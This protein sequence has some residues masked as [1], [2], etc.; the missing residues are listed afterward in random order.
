MK[1]LAF[2]SSS[3]PETSV[4][5]DLS[6]T[7]KT[8]ME[9]DHSAYELKSRLAIEKQNLNLFEKY[10]QGVLESDDVMLDMDTTWSCSFVRDTS[11]GSGTEVHQSLSDSML[12]LQQDVL[13]N[14]RADKNFEM[15]LR[16]LLMN[17]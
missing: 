13:S 16:S 11:L 6:T 14:Q 8:T 4:V 17:E 5:L 12:M 1:R 15:R 9:A 3:S 7:S 10:L 2:D